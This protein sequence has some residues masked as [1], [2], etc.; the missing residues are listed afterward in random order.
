MK[1]AVIDSTKCDRSPFCPAKIVCPVEA[2]TQ[3]T[4]FMTFEMPVIHTS[5]CVGCE[6][7]V[8]VCPMQAVSMQ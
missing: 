3:K 7:C 6:K 4:G 1:V 5:K 2:I 8:R